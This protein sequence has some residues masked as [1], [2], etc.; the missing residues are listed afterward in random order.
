M[1]DMQLLADVL[2]IAQNNT[3]TL[4]NIERYRKP[5]VN[6]DKMRRLRDDL[7]KIR[8]LRSGLS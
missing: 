2:D 3:S 8:Q 1:S 7:G 5:R 4:L 6:D